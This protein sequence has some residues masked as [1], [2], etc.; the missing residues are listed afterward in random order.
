MEVAGDAR[1]DLERAVFVVFDRLSGAELQRTGAPLATLL[2]LADAR[3]HVAL[4]RLEVVVGDLAHL[5][6]HL[7]RQQLLAQRRVV[8]HLGLGRRHDG[9]QGPRDAA[10]H[11]RVEEEHR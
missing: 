3:Q 4:E 9:L 10:D 11:E 1:F 5:A 6:L 7:G 2:D 8:V